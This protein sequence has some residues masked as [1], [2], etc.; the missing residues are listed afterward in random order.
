MID[1]A[2]MRAFVGVGHWIGPFCENSPKRVTAAA[3]GR[4][5]LFQ[6]F[7]SKP[8]AVGE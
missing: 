7:D 6:Y 2:T 1:S 4:P 5:T 8:V 3:Y